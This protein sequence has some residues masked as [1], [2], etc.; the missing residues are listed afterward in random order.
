MKFKS[1]IL[2]LM[3][4]VSMVAGCAEKEEEGTTETTTETGTEA[5]TEA[6]DVVVTA[7]IVDT[8]EAL[9]KAAGPDVY[10]LFAVVKDMTVE[11]E[12][13][14]EGEFTKE[15]KDDATKLVP[16][17]RKFALYAQDEDRNKTASYTV[18]APKMTV[19]SETTKV[20]GGTFKGDVYVEAN[21]FNLVDATIDGNVYFA[22]DEFKA[23]FTM[24]EKSKVTGVTEVK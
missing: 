22:S 8:P 14:V 11:S 23:S 13:V 24:D 12:I 17:G 9:L 21:G 5:A 6:V 10:W 18:T 7:S 15:D 3:I 20:Q 19:K 2:V 16:A 1:L 4:A